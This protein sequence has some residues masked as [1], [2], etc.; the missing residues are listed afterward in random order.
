M[1]AQLAADWQRLCSDFM[2]EWRFS[3]F[4]AN[5]RFLRAEA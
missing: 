2:L 4:G 1:R 5:A 3:Q